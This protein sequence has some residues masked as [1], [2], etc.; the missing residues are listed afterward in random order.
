[1][2]AGRDMASAH[3]GLGIGDG[4][5][6]AVVGHLVSTLTVL[7]MPEDTI[8]TVTASGLL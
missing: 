6:D 2:F 5:F 3:A 4:D 8:T 7:G 1:M